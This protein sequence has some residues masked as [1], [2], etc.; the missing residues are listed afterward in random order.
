MLDHLLN[1]IS[2]EPI[3]RSRILWSSP[4]AR[5][6]IEFGLEGCL[7]WI[8]IVEPVLKPLAACEEIIIVVEEVMEQLT[9]TYDTRTNL[10]NRV[11]LGKE[12]QLKTRAWAKLS[13]I[14][15]LFWRTAIECD[16]QPLSLRALKRAGGPVMNLLEALKQFKTEIFELGGIFEDAEERTKDK[17]GPVRVLSH[18]EQLVVNAW[19]LVYGALKSPFMDGQVQKI[20]ITGDFE[21]LRELTA[22]VAHIQKTMGARYKGVDIHPHPLTGA[23]KGHVTY[24]FPFLNKDRCGHTNRGIWRIVFQKTR[25]YGIYDDHNGSLDKWKGEGLKKTAA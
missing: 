12:L 8:K 24:D 4:R 21:M 19:T 1:M 10:F 25:I 6:E 16:N 20:I 15:A 18:A 17:A 9:L 14:C 5:Q 23:L 11:K 13:P 3:A 2:A 22:I 7:Q